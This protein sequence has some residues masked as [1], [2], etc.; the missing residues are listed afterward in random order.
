MTGTI[1]RSVF[2]AAMIL[3]FCVGAVNAQE[4]A[5][6]VA[7]GQRSGEKVRGPITI[8][9]KGVNT[10]RYETRVGRNVTF[11]D[12][13]DLSFPFIRAVDTAEQ[14]EDTTPPI[15]QGGA[16]RAV[17]CDEAASDAAQCFNRLVQS[18]GDVAAAW[19]SAGVAEIAQVLNT[20]RM[21]AAVV[22]AF[23]STSD[24]SLAADDAAG[25]L[26]GI[27]DAQAAITEI[28]SLAWP[29]MAI[30]RAI[31][32]S[33]RIWNNLLR[34]S[35]F[36]SFSEW[37]A[38]NQERYLAF[39][40]RLEAFRDDLSERENNSELETRLMETQ[41]RA[42]EWQSIFAGIK[43]AGRKAFQRM[44]EIDCEGP[45]WQ[46]S[47]TSVEIVRSDRMAQQEA[48]SRESVIVVECPTVLSVSA[49][50]GLTMR[51]VTNYGI[52][53]SKSMGDGNEP[54]TAVNTF[55]I[56]ESAFVRPVP[57][58]LLHTRLRQESNVDWHFSVGASV[59][60]D[61]GD[62][63]HN[64]DYLFGPSLS[65]KGGFYVSF[66]LHLVRSERLA[67]DW[68]EG[69][70]VPEGVSQPPV[71]RTWDPAFALMFTYRV[72]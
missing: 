8:L 33:D 15:Q 70:L 23:V 53:S 28:L 21:K 13:P 32:D 27:D 55:G 45:Q 58:V 34:L 69:A 25:V 18:F 30:Q 42:V 61:A 2:A 47:S 40:N 16:V 10:L 26:A 36:D 62:S 52:V 68:E 4:K 3:G 22:S 56:L 59:K 51:R 1:V 5:I 12:A 44:V 50:V 37:M 19:R 17:Q 20:A 39:V 64:V 41:E 35:S 67:D 65:V 60:G 43:R 72:R 14:A 66:A 29:T 71:E 24:Q 57:A 11:I 63:G 49:G 6:N 31:A 46:T 9:L 54:G 38:A 7:V 48:P